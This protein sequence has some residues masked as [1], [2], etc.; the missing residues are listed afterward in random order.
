MSEFSFPVV[1]PND[2]FLV[3]F[4]LRGFELQS[5]DAGAPLTLV[6]VEDEEA[7]LAVN[8]QSQS[9]GELVFGS[10]GPPNPAQG[11]GLIA[12]NPATLRFRIPDSI[13]TLPL[14]L[15]R[16]LDWQK[17]E[18]II[19]PRDEIPR[20]PSDET[21]IE[22]PFRLFLNPTETSRWEH[23][24]PP[25][26]D[27]KRFGLWSTRLIGGSGIVP[28]FRV[29]WSP[30]ITEPVSD[31][32]PFPLRAS[33]R[34]ALA[35]TGHALTPR[36]L[37]LS[38]LGGDLQVEARFGSGVLQHWEHNIALGRETR[39][40]AESRGFLYPF[41]HAAT[42]TDFTERTFRINT[43]RDRSAIL[44]RQTFITIVE[45]ERTY[46]ALD[47]PFRS[48]KITASTIETASADSTIFGVPVI[49]TDWSGR[50]QKFLAPALFVEAN[51]PN[52]LSRAKEIYQSQVLA[53][54]G[55]PVTYVRPATTPNS[56][57]GTFPT[58]S[59]RITSE[60]SPDADTGFRPKLE[61]A[62][63]W[64]EAVQSIGSEPRNP[65]SF[66]YN[67]DFLR[68][69]PSTSGHFADLDQILKPPAAGRQFGGVVA[70]EVN[71]NALTLAQGVSF[72]PFLAPLTLPLE[73]KLLGFIPLR[74]LVAFENPQ[75]FPKFVTTT[76]ED[77]EMSFTCSAT[78][79]GV[80]QLKLSAVYPLAGARKYEIHGTLTNFPLS[81]GILTLR[82]IKLSFRQTQGQAPKVEDV[83][84]KLEF[85]ENLRFIAAIA[86]KLSQSAPGTP[87]GTRVAVTP[88][89]VL[90][91]FSATLPQIPM[92][93]FT[94]LNLA[95][96]A[97]LLLKFD[98]PM[99]MEF[100]LS[101][102]EKP[103]LVSYSAIGGGGYFRLVLDAKGPKLIEFSIQLGAV[104]EVDF[105]VAR[106]SAQVLIAIAITKESDH[107]TKFEGFLR[108]H[109]AVEVL[110]LVTVSIDVLLTLRYEHPIATGTVAV[111]IMIQ[112]LA[113]SRS[114][115]FSITR[116]F[117]TRNLGDVIAAGGTQ[118]T[119][120]LQAERNGFAE[121]VDFEQWSRYC[122]AFAE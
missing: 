88:T 30:D 70:P 73:G 6:R 47:W 61:Q 24:P 55:Q 19:V 5:P 89:G 44:L 121:T 7:T 112:V 82:F 94:L 95:L 86:E 97:S 16:L 64:L 115:S 80:G 56:D 10:D 78:L 23:D 45:V 74:D 67:S 103:F 35:S 49:A 53:L 48:L 38:A 117:D 66:H 63:V 122:N 33:H 99:E 105:F 106:G 40:R 43:D 93:Q 84:A 77:R 101:S 46:E 65:V 32:V 58:K 52:A 102:R 22:M 51:D 17:F 79:G 31:G 69:I 8:F 13:Q 83:D 72:V 90:A 28:A 37:G 18:P 54:E 109:G 91:S 108:I 100:S 2:L 4:E 29:V 81:L 20:P 104:A 1:R 111:T 87:S 116:S 59:L 60:D 110:K 11:L 27:D 12:A 57:A 9:F 118:P 14:T 120:R 62:T 41:Q 50:E 92:G 68:Q 36:R 15:E 3:E 119:R 98:D 25:A 26:A 42:R 113:F 75:S 34:V 85:A 107:N 114:V 96:S 71:L 76:G 39:V 21:S